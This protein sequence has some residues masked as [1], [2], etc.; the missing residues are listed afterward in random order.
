MWQSPSPTDS[1]TK[2]P[3]SS[4]PESE[5]V[6]NAAV[7]SAF[8]IQPAIWAVSSLSMAYVALTGSGLTGSATLDPGNLGNPAGTLSQIR[9]Q[10]VSVCVPLATPLADAD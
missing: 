10:P 2:P 5:S 4:G 7:S 1:R 6:R 8:C 3:S 9:P